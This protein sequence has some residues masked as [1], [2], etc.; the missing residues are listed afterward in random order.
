LAI[1]SCSNTVGSFDCICPTG[2]DGDGINACT[3]VDECVLA[4][5]A[6]IQTN[7]TTNGTQP[8]NCDASAI[9]ID[10]E[11]SYTCV[12]PAGT[13]ENTNTRQCNGMIFRIIFGTGP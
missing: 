3:N 7:V 10:T 2:F 8:A 4:L 13:I 6:P 1:S 12:C 9:C 11:G 5:S